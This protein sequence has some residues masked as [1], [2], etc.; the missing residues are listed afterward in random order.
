MG[1]NASG[2]ERLRESSFYTEDMASDHSLETLRQSI[3]ILKLEADSMVV[4]G[5]YSLKETI[6]TVAQKNI[7]YLEE[8]D[9][10]RY[11]RSKLTTIQEMFHD[12][13]IIKQQLNTNKHTSF[14][15]CS[16]T[17]ED[18][19]DSDPPVID[20]DSSEANRTSLNILNIRIIFNYIFEFLEINEKP[21]NS[22]KY[23]LEQIL[24]DY[25]QQITDQGDNR[26]EI[27]ELV[28][29]ASILSIQLQELD[30]FA[31]AA[32]EARETKLLSELN[33]FIH[34]L[35]NG[36]NDDLLRV[37]QNIHATI[38]QLK[39]IANKSS[40][41]AP[42]FHQELAAKLKLNREKMS[43]EA[44]TDEFGS[45]DSELIYENISTIQEKLRR[46]ESIDRKLR[47]PIPLPRNQEESLI[48][49]LPIHWRK[50]NSFNEKTTLSEE[51]QRELVMIREDVL[52]A[53]ILFNN[54]IVPL[55]QKLDTSS[56]VNEDK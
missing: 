16:E 1:N 56:F 12:L 50:L 51:D 34:I 19:R 55:I 8:L 36:N 9:Y 4:N 20:L 53:A 13:Q 27:N 40:C 38:T 32:S 46:I 26:H 33:E 45:D 24:T 42:P 17:T 15:A 3:D 47:K 5:D 23:L 22:N 49:R 25:V 28:E 10:M 21:I 43:N 14:E 48:K 31:S 37:Q 54:M 30:I 29:L 39:D 44:K 35:K 18:T 52:E 41:K 2:S 6:L 7:N 11:E